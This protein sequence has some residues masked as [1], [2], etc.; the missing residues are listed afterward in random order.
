MV[1]TPCLLLRALCGASL[2]AAASNPNIILMMG[3]DH[4]LVIREQKD[5]APAIEL[6]DLKSDPAEK[7]NLIDQKPELARAL[8][9]KLRHWQDSALK[10]L[11][12][13]DYRDD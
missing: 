10:S 1:L 9:S 11:T 12:G 5:G 13:A 7:S 4:K 6:F 3:D 8:Q 2:A